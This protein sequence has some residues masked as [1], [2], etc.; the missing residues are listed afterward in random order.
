MQWDIGL[1]IGQTGVRL[2]TRERGEALSSPAWG[3]VR[4]GETIALGDEAMH[5]RGRTLRDVRVARPVEAGSVQDMRLMG[6]WLA[7]TLGPLLSASRLSRPAVALVDSG[8][9]RKS[10][11][12][13]MRAAAL[14]LGAARCGFVQADLLAAIGSGVDVTD[15]RGVLVVRVGAGT[16]SALIISYGR[17]VRCARCTQGTEEIDRGIV[18]LLREECALGV[19]LEQA[20]ALKKA[21]C[22]R[23]GERAETAPV[24]GLDLATGFP[25]RREVS[26]GLIKRAVDPLCDTA[27]R[28]MLD[29]LGQAPDEL[30]ADLLDSGIVLTG[31]GAHIDGLDALLSEQSGLKCRV[32]ETPEAASWHGMA[33]LLRDELL[34][35]LI[36]G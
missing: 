12:D 11:L 33:R 13:L 7:Q 10:E 3:A 14:E 35:E 6:G 22:A 26:A 15:P 21:L 17:I 34:S 28:L 23:L 27:L 19:G 31:G 8:F 25:T 36:E 18:R 29:V 2:C 20:E 5:M 32:A 16:M 1:E 30:C 4:A 24:A 9:F